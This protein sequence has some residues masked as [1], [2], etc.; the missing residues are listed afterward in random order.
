M[1]GIEDKEILI[2]NNQSQSG[3]DRRCR[4]NLIIKT[5]I[6]LD[7]I[8]T[9]FNPDMIFLHDGERYIPKRPGPSSIS[10]ERG[11]A[12]FNRICFCSPPNP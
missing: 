2:Q 12:C 9:G 3:I 4:K 10:F 6:N 5:I 1:F 7:A 11:Q 8:K